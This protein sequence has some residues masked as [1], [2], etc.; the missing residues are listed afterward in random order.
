MEVSIQQS[1]IVAG[2]RLV[3]DFGQIFRLTLVPVVFILL[4]TALNELIIIRQFWAMFDAPPNYKPGSIALWL[5]SILGVLIGLANLSIFV[6]ICRFH[7]YG[8]TRRDIS[9]LEEIRDVVFV[10]LYVFVLNIVWVLISFLLFIAIDIFMPKQV[11]FILFA[12]FFILTLYVLIRIYTALPGVAIGLRPHFFR[13]LWPFAV[14]KIWALIGWLL[15]LIL[16]SII[17]RALIS[18]IFIGD[19]NIFSHNNLSNI[20]HQIGDYGFNIVAYSIIEKTISL[21]M[22]LYFVLFLSDVF[23]QI[24]VAKGILQVVDPD[25]AEEV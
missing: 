6:R 5:P 17:F 22:L 11:H 16:A 25:V 20:A 24:A 1:V 12:I 7:I 4:A 14:G 3:Q 21:L 15:L 18:Y 9:S 23:R 2:Q 19:Y 13:D 8:D 10:L